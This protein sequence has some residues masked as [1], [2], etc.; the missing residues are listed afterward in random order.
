MWSGIRRSLCSAS[1][2]PS[3][4]KPSVI[5]REG[6]RIAEG[7]TRLGCIDAEHKLLRIPDHMRDVLLAAET[8]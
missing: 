1:M 2:Q 6:T 7:F 8:S 4:V 5:R 3:R